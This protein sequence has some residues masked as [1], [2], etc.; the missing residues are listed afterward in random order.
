[1]A[2]MLGEQPLIDE[3]KGKK[4]LSDA[5]PDQKPKGDLRV[6]KE[7]KSVDSSVVIG[8]EKHQKGKEEQK[9]PQ[10]ASQTLPTALHLHISDV[11]EIADALSQHDRKVVSQPAVDEHQ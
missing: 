9:D 5:S 8:I 7:A 6:V 10:R 1:M 3:T 11:D 4:D 2:A